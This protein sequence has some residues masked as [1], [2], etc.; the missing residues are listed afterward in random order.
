[1]GRRRAQSLR[2][3]AFAQRFAARRVASLMPSLVKNHCPRC[4]VA[5]RCIRRVG[6]VGQAARQA[7]GGGRRR[8]GAIHWRNPGGAICAFT[9]SHC[10]LLRLPV[11]NGCSVTNRRAC[12]FTQPRSPSQR[13]R[14]L[15]AAWRISAR[16]LLLP[17]NAPCGPILHWRTL[18]CQTRK[19]CMGTWPSFGG[20]RSRFISKRSMLR[21]QARSR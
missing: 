17:I 14:A 12:C 6:Q 10:T 19:N 18:R 7:R 1:M 16:V 2:L 13:T 9:R 5:R 21:M 8:G 3:G 4:A 20:A 15:S 11:T